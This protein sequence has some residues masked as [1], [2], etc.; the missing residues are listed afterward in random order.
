MDWWFNVVEYL[1]TRDVVRFR[2][3]NSLAVEAV[4]MHSPK[5]PVYG[6]VRNFFN[7]F[8]RCAAVTF[9]AR[10]F[11][12]ADFKAMAHVTEVALYWLPRAHG[13]IAY[14]FAELTSLTSLTL[15]SSKPDILPG[16][17]VK[18]LPALR[19]LHLNN[20]SLVSDNDIRLLKLQTLRL[21]NVPY[22]TH[23]GLWQQRDLKD[24]TLLNMPQMKGIIFHST[25]IEKLR[26]SHCSVRKYEL[27]TL[28]ALRELSV[29]AMDIEFAA[30]ASLPLVKVVL[31]STPIE[32]EDLRFLANVKNI[33]LDSNDRLTGQG[34][35][36]LRGVEELRLYRLNLLEEHADNLLTL[37]VL[38]MTTIF[39]CLTISLAKKK[40]LF[41][42]MGGRL[43]AVLE[44]PC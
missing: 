17:V 7:C 15:V 27:H 41:D 19:H 5:I 4:K 22:F 8:P 33:I 12:H 11:E 16:Y 3:V 26:L 13:I 10:T 35:C 32:D 2:G 21:V 23:A 25:A 37:P 43:T 20:N 14:Y 31:H 34:L 1:G 30:L 29:T 40:F 18:Y 39:D 28:T 36:Y 24:L 44:I 9:S 6:S 38:K 42:R